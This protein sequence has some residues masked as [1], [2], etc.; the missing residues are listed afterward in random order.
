MSYYD[1]EAALQMTGTDLFK[2]LLRL[3]PIAEYEDY[4]TAPYWKNDVLKTDLQLIAAHREEGGA[5][6]PIPLDKVKLPPGC[7]VH[8]EAPKQSPFAGAVAGSTSGLSALIAARAQALKDAKEK[9]GG[10]VAGPGGAPVASSA[11]ALLAARAKAL[12]D[13]KEKA[14]QFKLAHAGSVTAAASGGGA[15]LRLMA[16]FVAKWKMEPARTKAMLAALE[17]PQRRYVIQHFKT[18]NAGEAATT[19]IEAFIADCKEK[20]AWAGA[21]DAPLSG[22]KRPLAVASPAAAASAAE[23]NKKPAMAALAGAGALRLKILAAQQ[24]KLAAA[25]G[26]APAAPTGGLIK[27]LLQ[28]NS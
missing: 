28:Q 10:A 18:T 22:L 14:E 1:I 11:V 7:P 6:D 4:Y 3:Y 5:P 13:A 17:P 9:A 27:G 25:G 8:R 20:D 15:E 23:P 2:E 12:K 19:E 26:A 21:S 24:A 16:L